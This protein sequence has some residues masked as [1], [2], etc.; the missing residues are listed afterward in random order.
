MAFGDD[1]TPEEIELWRKQD[2]VDNFMLRLEAWIVKKITIYDST[3]FFNDDT[4]EKRKVK[5]GL[6]SL[7]GIES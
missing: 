7:L 1:A 5:E 6:Q 3:A 4:D 2:L